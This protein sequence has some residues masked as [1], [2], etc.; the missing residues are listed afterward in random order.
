MVKRKD[1]NNSA[2]AKRQRIETGDASESRACESESTV[3]LTD[4]ETFLNDDGAMTSSYRPILIS[5]SDLESSSSSSDASSEDLKS[6]DLES[7][8]T[9]SN[10]ASMTEEGFQQHLSVLKCRYRAE[11]EKI[12]DEVRLFS[13]NVFQKALLDCFG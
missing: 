4:S 10:V 7:Q 3:S 12:E 9:D 1:P 6:N 11:L 8:M 13:K 5:V 2:Q